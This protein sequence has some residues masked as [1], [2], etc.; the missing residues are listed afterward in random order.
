MNDI[1]CIK[2][3][4][5]A[6]DKINDFLEVLRFC[7]D[8]GIN[9]L[10]LEI[11]GA[12]E[13]KRH[14]EINVGW[15]EYASHFRGSPDAAFRA[16]YANNFPKN[17][18][19]WENGG[20]SFLKQDEIK[21]IVAFCA[22]MGISVIPELPT[23]THCD[24]F[25]YSHHDLAERKEDRF[26]DHYCP[27][28]EKV[29]TLLFDLLD[30]IIDVFQPSVINIGHDELYTVCLCER[31]RKRE[32]AELYAEDIDRIY[33]Y[34]NG[35]N[36]RTAMWADKLYPS[37][38]KKGTP[39]GGSELKMEYRP[40]EGGGTVTV[41][42]VWRAAELL[43]KDILLFHWHY[44]FGE[45][46]E[47]YFETLGFEYVFAN[48]N[49]LTMPDMRKR[50]A[51]T[52]CRGFCLSNWSGI[53]KVLLQRNGIFFDVAF[54]RAYQDGICSDVQPLD[55]ILEIVSKIVCDY[56]TAKIKDYIIVEHASLTAVPHR[57][58]CDGNY[59]DYQKDCL[60]EYRIYYEDGSI[61]TEKIYFGLNINQKYMNY[62]R[63]SDED[64][65]LYDVDRYLVES[66]Y[67]CVYKIAGG[68][69]KYRCFFPRASDL[70][71][72]KWE[73]CPAVYGNVVETYKLSEG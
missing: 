42:A 17:A 33:T 61:Q 64:F 72:R 70:P 12:M 29:Y 51:K 38:T 49:P 62:T 69:T 36:I 47:D 66:V 1:S 27:S 56:R 25:L 3:F 71:I 13:Y 40:E 18:I 63:Q 65:Y 44:L 37:K 60:G 52:R 48:L 46:A 6:R 53:D 14:P 2:L 31:C 15:V 39:F 45:A 16:Q 24:Y 22:Q 30:E 10:M 55:E 5:P 58:F 4:L 67:T 43:P 59:M 28:N 35:K 54:M 23:L 8:F 9:T 32:A 7:S 73:F 21:R 19:H 50:F 57:D 41:P 26:A 34:L 68:E 11:G 20:G